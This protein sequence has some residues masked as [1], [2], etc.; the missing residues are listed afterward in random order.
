MLEFLG[1]R[2]TP[3]LSLLPDRLWPGVVAPDGVL[4]MDQIELFNISTNDLSLVE[5]FELE[6]YYH[7]TVCK[8]ITDD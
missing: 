2:N 7:L 6:L 8:Q 5:L 4:S 3:S 1:M